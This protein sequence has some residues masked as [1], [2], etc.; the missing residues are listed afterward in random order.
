[1]KKR[2]LFVDDEPR[3]LKGLQRMLH[4]Q[5]DAWDMTFATGS[6]K[7]TELLAQECYDAA[8]LDIKMP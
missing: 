7:A 5:T 3:V 2:I 8:V 6:A 4:D 1:M